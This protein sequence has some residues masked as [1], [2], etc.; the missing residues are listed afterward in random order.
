MSI[1]GKDYWKSLDQLAETEEFKNFLHREFPENA[2]ELPASFSRRKFITLMGASLA[3]AGLAA[4]R[5]PV[6]KIV[7]YVKP[8]E[9]VVPGN[10]L[11]FAT[12]M[13][14]STRAYGVVVKSNE[15]RPTKIEGND[16]HPSS[17]GGS[18][19]FIQASILS[20]YDPD[21]SQNVLHH[22][23]KKKWSDF[24]GFWKD[25]L[26]KTYS[27]KRGQGLAILSAPFSSPT[28]KRLFSQFRKSFPQATWAT[29]EPVSDENIFR[30]L[31]A[32]TGN[33]LIPDYHLQS[34]QVIVALDADILHM[35]SDNVKNAYGFAA[36]RKVRS[37]KDGMNRLYAVE[38]TFSVTGASADHRL[39]L[40]SGLVGTFVLQLV[41]ELN[42]LGLGLE[43][44]TDKPADV[45]D[46]HQ[47]RWIKALAK[48]IYSN[49]GKS[50]LVAGRQQPAVVHAIVYALNDKLGNIGK[51]VTYRLPVDTI[52]PDRQQLASLIRQINNGEI[53][54]LVILGGNPAYDAPADLDF[55]RALKK[56]KHTIHLSSHVDETS[57]NVEW[58]IPQSHFLEM[59]G[60]ARAA[61]GTLS[62][63]QPLIAPLFDSHSDAQVL[64]LIASGNDR[65]DYEIVRE[66]WQKI[67][68]VNF[69]KQWRRILHDGV[70][71]KKT[72]KSVA[73]AARTSAI[74][75]LL[76]KT[77][78]SVRQAD[79]NLLEVVFY[80]SRTVYDG[81]FANNGWLQ[82][83][84]DPV[85]K[86]SWDNV[87]VM[88][89]ATA[90]KLNL[91]NEDIV[92]VS[93]Q[94]RE[95]EMAV[96]VLPG[97]AD[98]SL[99]LFLGYG[100][101]SPGRVANGVGF[102]TFSI[103]TTGAFDF[104][105]GATLTKTGKTYQLANTQDH[106]SL[107]G[108][109]LLREAALSEYKQHPE[110]AREMVEHPP[111]KSLWK[112][113]KYDKGEQWGMTIDLNACIGCNACT[114]ACQSENNIPIVGKEQVRKGREMHWIRLDRYFNGSL[115]DPQMVHQPVACQQC[116]M[117]PC[118]QVCPVAATSHSKDGLNMMTYNRCIGTR[119]CSNN[120]P[121][122]VRRFNFF[123][124]TGDTPEIVKMA[125]NPDVTVRSRG[126]MEKCTYCVQ[127]INRARIAAKREGRQLQDG[128]IQTA[129]QQACPTKAIQFGDINDPNSTVAKLRKNNRSY[130]M[131][132]E[133]NVRPRTSYLAKLRNPNPEIEK[134]EQARA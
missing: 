115:D 18:N 78:L 67:I 56:I 62:V 104:A 48:D 61:D 20:L 66:T 59:W 58:H 49:R 6:E 130:E 88:S 79:E 122:K 3:L 93:F 92:R 83:L 76:K 132:A 64:N 99:A 23:T 107:E 45:F 82:E 63:I 21:R 31:A 2:S 85:T 77:H 98:Y 22:G 91:K 134:L 121:Y 128:E 60:D 97:Q 89:P 75:S 119:Y 100:R 33:P 47:R 19:V 112:E 90:D 36:G 68:P 39:K 84:P 70:Y 42:D 26:Y 95:S 102:N 65:S 46:D 15:G 10:P 55:L 86:L 120:C 50:I 35:E 73:P 30:G 43:L 9:E 51:T 53:E 81:R 105:V 117:A 94:G 116:E 27:A 8:P 133:L 17:L 24:V 111:L 32:A 87:L 74:N 71:A 72:V 1:T 126:V 106:W 57:L 7:P 52:L 11:Y 129:C 123:N 28:L 44:S 109:P 80:P 114:I 96:W 101:K 113:H 103:R 108:R 69:E 38:S 14:F 4:C 34:A 41:D 54:T 127:R 5:R 131:L 16:K 124:Y 13:P 118:E 29:Y 12:T 37:E 25:D 110:F 40:Q 125:Q